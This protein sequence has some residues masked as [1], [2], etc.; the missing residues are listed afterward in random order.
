MFHKNSTART[1]PGILKFGSPLAAF[2]STK[3]L[4][5]GLVD[6]GMAEF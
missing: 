4:P 1:R 5:C 6:W 3:G 2:H